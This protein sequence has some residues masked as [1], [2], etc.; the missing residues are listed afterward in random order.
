MEKNESNK[1]NIVLKYA[2]FTNKSPLIFF[3]VEKLVSN[4]LRTIAS[5]HVKSFGGF[6]KI[7]A[8]CGFLLL[9]E[10]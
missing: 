9:L 2:T 1:N 8:V 5:I 4:G 7:C 10:G 6:A 3:P